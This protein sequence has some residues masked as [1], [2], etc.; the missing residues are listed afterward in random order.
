MNIQL[1][2][3]AMRE[4]HVSPEQLAVSCAVSRPTIER[5]IDGRTTNPGIL[6]MADICVSLGLS[7]DDVMDMPRAAHGASAGAAGPAQ[8]AELSN[9]YRAVI[10]AKDAWIRRLAV[11]CASLVAWVMLCWLVDL[12]NPSV[13]WVTSQ[14]HDSAVLS[15][16]LVVLAMIGGV[17][18][19]IISAKNA[20]SR[21]P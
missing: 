3:D 15:R 17:V 19:I 16:V 8:S 21:R 12:G 4:K 18:C 14:P 2:T 9:L 7:L 6:T 13:G 11:A 1:I 20:K 5:I 10:Y